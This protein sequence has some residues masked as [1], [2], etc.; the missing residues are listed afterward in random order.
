MVKKI[1]IGKKHLGK[2][3]REMEAKEAAK[4]RAQETPLTERVRAK[5]NEPY[6]PKIRKAIKESKKE[7]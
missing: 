4:A 7:K 6:S 1:E 5:L 3:I 2:T